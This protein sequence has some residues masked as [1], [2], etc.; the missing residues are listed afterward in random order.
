MKELICYYHQKKDFIIVTLMN[1]YSR[2]FI[3]CRKAEEINITHYSKTQGKPHTSVNILLF[4]LMHF[5]LYSWTYI[6]SLYTDHN[7][8]LNDWCK[9]YFE[10]SHTLSCLTISYLSFT[11]CLT[12][13]LLSLPLPTMLNW[14]D[15]KLI[16]VKTVWDMSLP[17]PVWS[18]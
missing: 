13:K 12:S 10:R 16:L 4:F 18:L 3:K 8:H 2:H 6:S 7:K 15:H 17:W 9:Y 14:S 5:L 1:V 11:P